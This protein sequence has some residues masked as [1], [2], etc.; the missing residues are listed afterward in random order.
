[1]SIE[2]IKKEAL[3]G[4]SRMSRDNCSFEEKKIYVQS[5]AARLREHFESP[6]HLK[7]I[8]SFVK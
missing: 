1:M 4:L 8:I 7:S 2:E 6:E 3:E 5:I